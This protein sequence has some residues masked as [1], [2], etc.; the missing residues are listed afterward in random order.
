MCTSK[1]CSIIII[2]SL[3][4]KHASQSCSFLLLYTHAKKKTSVR[5]VALSQTITMKSSTA[6]VLFAFLACLSFFVV[7][8]D[9][10]A[11]ETTTATKPGIHQKTIG[12]SLDKLKGKDH[13]KKKI[14]YHGFTRGT[15]VYPDLGSDDDLVMYE[16][17]KVVYDWACVSGDEYKKRRGIKDE[18][19]FLCEIFD[20]SLQIYAK[21]LAYRLNEKD[22][23]TLNGLGQAE[24]E[25]EK[26]VLLLQEATS[27]VD[28]LKSGVKEAAERKMEFAKTHNWLRGEE[29]TK[30]SKFYWSYCTNN[31]AATIK[32]E[33]RRACTLIF[34]GSND[35]L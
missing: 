9:A 20:L 18:I 19:T 7:I 2:K 4:F 34:A 1:N 22:L 13:P 12:D 14:G 10:S 6:V 27:S 26:V 33:I 8:E 5:C 16:L 21:S 23:E 11:A 35:E 17:D 32:S 30:L 31:K 25:T 15:W 3:V 28:S 29:K 24:K